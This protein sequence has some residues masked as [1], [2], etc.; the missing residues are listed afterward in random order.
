MTSKGFEKIVTDAIEEGR[1]FAK[2]LN[3]VSDDLGTY[4]IEGKVYEVVDL[5][6]NDNEEDC[7]I[8]ECEEDELQV[9]TYDRDFTFYIDEN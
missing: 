8:L 1:Y 9:S 3:S 6:K 5:L 7:Y 2:C 4:C